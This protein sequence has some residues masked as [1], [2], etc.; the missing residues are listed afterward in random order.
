MTDWPTL[1]I[2]IVTYDRID[3]LRTTLARLH[4]HL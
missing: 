2:N 1:A 3:T 4:T